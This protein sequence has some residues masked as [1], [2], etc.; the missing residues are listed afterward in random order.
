[1]K[2]F[3]I[4]FLLILSSV[5]AASHHVRQDASGNGNDWANAYGSLPSSLTR[6][7]TYYIADGTYNSYDFDDTGTQLI[8]IKKATIA[9]HGTNTGWQDSY[10]DGQAVFSSPLEFSTANWL[11][12]GQVWHG[13]KVNCNNVA[14]GGGGGSVYISGNDVTIRYVHLYGTYSGGWGHSSVATGQNTKWQY[15]DF[16]GSVYEDNMNLAGN[17]GTY[18]IDHCRFNHEGHPNDGSHRDL[19]NPWTNGGFNLDFTNNIVAGGMLDCLLFQN[20]YSGGLKLGTVRIIG[21]VFSG[22]QRAYGFGSKS[23]GC[24]QLI[25]EN[26]VYHNIQDNINSGTTWTSKTTRNNIYASGSNAN[27]AGGSQYCAWM[28]GASGYTTGTGNFNNAAPNFINM[29]SPDGADGIPFTEDDGFNIKVASDLIDA[30]TNTGRSQDIL[31][32]SI[33]EKPD[34]GTYEYASQL[35]DCDQTLSA[36]ANIRTAVSSAA[37]GSTICLNDGSY[38]GVDFSDISKTSYVTVRSKNPGK[39]TISGVTLHN[40]DYI[41]IQDVKLSGASIGYCSQNLELLGNVFTSG[42]SIRADGCSPNNNVNYL[43]DGNTFNNLVPATWEGRLSIGL[44]GS[45]SGI[46]ISNNVFG[47]G[48]CS[49]GIQ[50]V[51]GA[52]RVQIGPGNIFRDLVQGSCG[53]HV[54][55]IQFYGAGPGNIIEGNYFYHNTVDIGIYDGGDTITVRDNVF[56]TPYDIGY[57]A[58]QLG[59]IHGMLMEHNTFKDTLVGVGT[60]SANSQHTGW[61]VQNNIFENSDFNAAGDQPGCGNDCIVRYNLLS[62]G[63]TIYRND[64]NNIVGN[65]AY[66]G[67]GSVG[68]WGGWQLDSGSPGKNAGNDGKDMGT[69]FFGDSHGGGT[70]ECTGT[71]TSC[72]VYPS[73]TNCNSQDGCYSGSYRDYK[74]SGSSCSYTTV[75]AV[76]SDAAGNCGDSID[77]D[78]DGKA[79]SAD[80]DCACLVSTGSWQ[81]T[82]VAY[83]FIATPMNSNMNGVI[84]LSGSPGSTYEDFAVLVRF[85]DSGVI[86]VKNG[87]DYL[88]DTEINYN[89]SQQYYFNINVNLAAKTYD[90]YVDNT[91]VANDYAFR[92][93]QS[94]TNGINNLGIISESGSMQVCFDSCSISSV[95][96]AIESWKSG[97][98]T[99]NQVM[100]A[101]TNWK[102]C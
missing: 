70:L 66:T 93:E 9:D 20:G 102:T 71:D 27:A 3:S 4:I 22:G 37:A 41:R 74:C 18:V 14:G 23:L 98:I 2:R 77:N 36:G 8:T 45:D 17:G 7:D 69:T 1:M 65:A 54:D 44:V 88:Y 12:D 40:C 52:G 15:C 47:G 62:R 64:G 53:E 24:T 83:S 26:N 60:K 101:I 81:N 25:D 92:I 75:N 55:A 95:I 61:I 80:P 11:F 35:S 32:K 90:V 5:S 57:Q 34:I 10:G 100:L 91:L 13:F 85:A 84:G 67:T 59:G 58:L 38:S 79:D 50:L 63:G 19:M 96:A 56:D 76:E 42:M 89:P 94:G 39:A 48:G 87:D 43:I 82:G 86:D 68:N 72:G 21:N 78:C 28:N 46:T 31:R 29:N 16:D 51:G 73:C 6:G 99:I 33:Q 97:Q 30:G 49:D